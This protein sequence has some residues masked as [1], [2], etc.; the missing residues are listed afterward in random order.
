MIAILTT[1]F[2]LALVAFTKNWTL[3][4][5]LVLKTTKVFGLRVTL[6][7]W[8]FYPLGR[9]YTKIWLRNQCFQNSRK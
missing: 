1:V 6:V 5:T 7:T 3:G 8:F 9:M 2:T 4:L